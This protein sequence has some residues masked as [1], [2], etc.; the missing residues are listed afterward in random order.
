M[1]SGATAGIARL[2]VGANWSASLRYG[3][4]ALHAPRDL[5]ELRRLVAG[6]RRIR[7][8]GTRH[9]F[10]PIADT[11]GDLVTLEGMPRDVEIDERAGTVT[12]PAAL[13]YG[14]LARL[15][16]P[17]HLVLEDFASLP[18]I[19]VAGSVATATHGSG[20][21]RRCLASGVRALQLVTA[22]GDVAELSRQEHPEV[23]DGAVVSL[24]ALGV[25]TRVTLEVAPAFRVRQAVYRDLPP[26]QLDG[27]P[28]QAVLASAYSVSLFTR[29]D[30][31]GFDQVWIKQRVA[32][33]EPVTWG[34]EFPTDPA[35]AFPERWRGARRSHQ[36]QHP[37]G[38][39]AD[40]CTDQS[41]TPGPPHERLPHFRLAFT[42]SSGRE[43]QSEY[44]I[45]RSDAA[46]AI[47]ALQAVASRITPALQVS[48]L[49]TVA[50]D[51]HWLSMAYGR[52]SVS[53]HFTWRID[54]HAIARA[55]PVVEEALAPFAP[56]PHWGKVTG[57]APEVVR[58]RYP[59]F[60][61]AAALV[62]RM[63]PR[64]VFSN[65]WARELGLG[66]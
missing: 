7:A 20:V 15:L 62:A 24:G 47:A 17:R 51:G 60:A 58:A 38:L 27:E 35:T 44:L 64:G 3:A 48:E 16:A 9:S 11:D 19:S 63:D 59:R 30:R 45:D 56:R 61:Q 53:V 43:V 46:A 49:R 36:Q 2:P 1:S 22:E 54:D 10:S 5:D 18:H 31:P 13:R 4:R 25:V 52:D 42:P 12:V 23:F 37:A 66:A 41:T 21:T 40:A 65:A 34:K 28:L 55:L 50:P 32:E 14:D 8:L 39:E 6:S 33:G 29:W 26:E 57:I